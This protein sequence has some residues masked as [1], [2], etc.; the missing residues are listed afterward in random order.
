MER[1]AARYAP[2]LA[3]PHRR[4]ALQQRFTAPGEDHKGKAVQHDPSIGQNKCAPA[5]RPRVSSKPATRNV[6]FVYI[7]DSVAGEFEGN[8]NRKTSGVYNAGARA[9]V[10][11]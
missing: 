5:R 8:G 6:D 10:V 9:I 3:Q 7:E 4:P 2:R 11:I 1:M